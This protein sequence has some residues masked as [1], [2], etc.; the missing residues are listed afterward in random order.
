M[1]EY[2]YNVSHSVQ[3]GVWH[4]LRHHI[5]WLESERLTDLKAQWLYALLSRLETPLDATASST[6]RGL[7][8][9]VVDLR[10]SLVLFHK[11]VCTDILQKP[12]HP[13]LPAHN[14][15]ISIVG[16][17]FGQLENSCSSSFRGQ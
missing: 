10:S 12:G 6:L 13:L 1:W 4:V 9:R 2:H 15:I 3:V 11:L 16:H 7:L 8:R 17:Y 5:E 14:I